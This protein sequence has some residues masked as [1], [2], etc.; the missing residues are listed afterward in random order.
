[1]YGF[2]ENNELINEA[3]YTV[4]TG[5]PFIDLSRLSFASR[6]EMMEAAR[7]LNPGDV[8]DTIVTSHSSVASNAQSR[9][10][11]NIR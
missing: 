3:N 11:N 7:V 10:V 5:D 1:M 8:F 2:T 4:G 9:A 6:K